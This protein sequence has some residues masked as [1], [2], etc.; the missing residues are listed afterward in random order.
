MQAEPRSRQDLYKDFLEF[1]RND[2]QSE[3][4]QVNRR[5]FSTLVWCF[6][7]PALVSVTILLLINLHVLPRSARAALDWLVLIF[8][9]FYSLY[10]LGSEVLSQVPATFRKGGISNTLGQSLNEAIWRERVCAG[11]A[12]GI[13]ARVDEWKWLVANFK[14]DLQIMQYRTRYLT[15]L[16]GAV[17]FLLMQGIDS[18]S[19]G[20]DPMDPALLINK[21]PLMGWLERSSNDVSQFVGLALF[22]V[23]LYLSGNQ[24]YHSLMRYLNCAELNLLTSEEAVKKKASPLS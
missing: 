14:V 17:F 9:I 22:L 6:L 3:R 8:P 11:M 1:I 4:H 15:A 23:L 13:H 10:V 21:N 7:L 20:S 5:M 16:A 18:L 2:I 19:G 12:Q 24:T